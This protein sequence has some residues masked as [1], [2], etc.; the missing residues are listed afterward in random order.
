MLFQRQFNRWFLVFTLGFAL[1][2]GLAVVSTHNYIIEQVIKEEQEDINRKAALIRSR[3]EAA[4]FRDTY[5]ADSL[6]TVVAIDPEF[7]MA[8]WDDVAG[9]LLT[10]A[11]YVRNVGLAPNDVISHVYPLKGNE[12][13]I[14]LDFR[15]RPEQYRTV[16]RARNLADVY[17]A[18]PVDL[19]QGGQAIIARF[20]IF[21]SPIDKSS[22]WGGVSVVINYTKL[23]EESGLFNLAGASVAIKNTE[24][25]DYFYGSQDTFFNAD[26]VVPISLPNGE[27]TLAAQY[28]I[29]QTPQVKQLSIFVY[30][31]CISFVL[32]TY[33][34]IGLFYRS[35]LKA[36]EQAFQDEL[37]TLPNRRFAIDLL[38]KLTT[39]RK[40][41]FV[42][43][44]IDL[45]DF[46]LINDV[47]GHE[48]GDALLAHVASRLRQS[49]RASD[50]VARMGGDEFIAVLRAARPG[51]VNSIINS[52]K[53]SV[54]S[55]ACAWQTYKLYPSLSI[56]HALYDHESPQSLDEVMAT[57]D[58]DMYRVKTLGKR[59]RSVKESIQG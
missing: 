16:L 52:I 11:S 56:G 3:I 32:A 31:I 20:P 51:D 41:S 25:L 45:N 50:I 59:E 34:M 49:V 29:E 17:I 9:K 30:A 19:V 14:G 15:A 55:R 21:L 44:N 43:L 23:F 42:L 33:G 4:I 53:T 22:Y 40:E 35:F 48:A 36:K 6:A 5:L 37:T 46:K 58:H 28:T 26:F 39:E 8:S 38:E 2:A 24:T 18:G 1:L 12:A 54:E 47:Y 10:K 57:A 13:A 27:W 7:A